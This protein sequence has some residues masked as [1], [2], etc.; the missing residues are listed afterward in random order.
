MKLDNK[1]LRI[2]LVEDGKVDAYVI[3]STLNKYM[4]YHCRVRHAENM[5]MAEVVLLG[6]DPVDLILLDLGLPDTKGGINTFQRIVDINKTI[7]VIILTSEHD[8]ELAVSIV[9]NGAEDYIRKSTM[10]NDPEV[11]CDAI[12]F[13]VCRHKHL[14]EIELEKK[15]DI[16][17]KDMVIQWVTGS[18]SVY[19][20]E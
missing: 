15:C 9:D 5:A 19:K 14:A 7:P 11:F 1:H 4:S 2:L 10:V 8:H 3:K 6:G 12:D 16:K 17:E 20:Q 13:A 18:Y